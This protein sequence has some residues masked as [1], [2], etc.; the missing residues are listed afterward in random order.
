MRE[1]QKTLGRKNK[2]INEKERMRQ[3]QRQRD[4]DGYK[5]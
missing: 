1:R 2:V 3:K 5:K 4:R